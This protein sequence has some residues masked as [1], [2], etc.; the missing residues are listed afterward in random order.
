MGSAPVALAQQ[1]LE[2]VE[3]T[4]S[5][6][7]R[8]EAETALPVTIIDA[9]DLKK[10]GVTTVE[11]AMSFVAQNQ[12]RVNTSNSIDT[13]R[14]GASFADLRALGPQ[15]TLVLLNGQRVVNNPYENVGVDLN[16][17]PAVAIDRIEVLRDGASAIYG[18]DAIAGVVNIITRSEY[19]GISVAELV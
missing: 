5:L 18:T 15:R 8:S 19:Q 9:E 2:H 6:I 13:F 4:G 16:A 12:S 17:I 11:Q 14:G 10:A 1:V 7:K 3:V